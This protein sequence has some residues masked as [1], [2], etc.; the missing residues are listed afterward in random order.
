VAEHRADGLKALDDFLPSYEFAA[1]YSIGVDADAG[2]AE[3]AV[4]EVT[5]R[6]VPV[7]RMLLFLRGLGAGRADQ[8]VVAAMAR[9][10]TVL[11]NVPGEGLVLGVRGRF[12]RLRGGGEEPEAA[13]VV[14]FR[15]RDGS[16][17]TETRVHVPDGV[18]RRRFRRYWL[19]VGPLSGVTRK[20]ILRAAKRR[21]ERLA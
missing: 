12:W 7:V 6:E 21:A 5:F 9:R 10:G 1:R 14:D 18:S 3:E 13:A 19:V 16:L 15:A 11:A 8:R 20:Q 2:V 17:T 4:R